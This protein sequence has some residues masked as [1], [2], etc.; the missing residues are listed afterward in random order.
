MSDTATVT[1]PA[2]TPATP[3]APKV[4]RSIQN[5]VIQ[6]FITDADT[7]ITTAS[8]DEVIAPLLATRGY[9]AAAFA[10]GAALVGTARDAF[11]G[12]AAGLGQQLKTT[13]E[14]HAAIATARD[15]YAA[16]REIVRG[17][18]PG[19]PERVALGVTGDMPVDFQRFI[20]AAHASY[21]AAGKTA[22]AAKCTLR[23]F[24]PAALA[25]LIGK[26]DALTD[27]GSGQDTD[28]GDAQADT[29]TRDAAYTALKAWMKELKATCRGELRGK[30]PL[31]AK[32]GL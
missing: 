29:A 21:T 25:A 11:A 26:L 7:F 30:K 5:T 4:R 8:T 6:K 14:L 15:D 27:D 2:T 9:D 31:L 1:Q 18:F 20:T 22:Y 17:V 23:G 16:F 3:Q 13:G 32:L 12:R 10:T 24:G 19:Q 28:E